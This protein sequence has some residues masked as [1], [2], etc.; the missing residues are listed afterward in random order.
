M[1]GRISGWNRRHPVLAILLVSLLAVV[2]N[3]YPV[4]FCG[5]SFVSPISVGRVVYDWWPSLPG[6]DPTQRYERLS[7]HGSDTGAAMWWEV[8]MGFVES[9]SL[10]EHG[11]IPLWNRYSHAG[12]TLIGQNETML[13]DP[14][15]LIVILGRG[16]AE[17]WDVKFVVAK[18]LFC[19]GFGLLILRLF[20]SRPLSL[21]YAAMGAYCGAFFYI[22]NHPSFF[23]LCYGPWILLSALA[24]LDR[25]SGWSAVWGLVWL[26]A[27]F[28]CFN[29]GHVETAVVL[30]GGLNLTAISF[31]LARCGKAIAAAK[32][33]GRMGLGTILFLGLTAPMWMSFFAALS[34]AFSIH[35]EVR[36]AQIPL[37]ALPGMFDD[38]FFLLPLRS[39]L[40]AA[41]AP[42]T[43]LLVMAG[44]IFSVLRWRELKGDI[45]F[46]VNGGA[47][48]LW[49]GFVFG[50]VPAPLIAAIP[51]LNRVGHVYVDFSYLLV[52]QLTIQSALGFTCLARE[53]DFRR[54]AVDLLWVGLIFGTMVL[55]FCLGI[56]H[57]PIPWN[58]FLCVAA[59]GIGAP[60]L[61]TYLKNRHR[62]IPVMGLAGIIILGFIPHFRFG[63]YTFG[64][65]NLLLIPGQREVLDAPSPAI[66]KIKSGRSDPFRVVGL[67][68]NLAGDYSA[69]YGLEDIRSCA[70]L[71]NGEYIKLMQK[72]PGVVFG[73]QSGW[74]ICVENPVAA[75]PLLNLLDVKYLLAQPQPQTEIRAGVDFRVADR[76]DFLVLENVDVWPRAFFSNK[77]LTNSSTEEFLKQLW[78]NSKQ[79]F[80]SLSPDEL[81]SQPGL[82]ALTNTKEAAILPATN[83]SMLPNS[84]AFDVHATSA[85]VVCL[86][87]GQAKD[88]TA[89]ANGKP[90]AV[91]TVNRAFKGVYLDQPG[92][93]HIE[94]IYR[95]RHWRLACL[96]FWISAASVMVLATIAAFC[97][98]LERQQRNPEPNPAI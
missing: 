51:L 36:V 29:A 25:Q 3:C 27:N 69:T 13:G 6:M 70:P 94:F 76:S 71:S 68:W 15:Q 22:N 61:F 32:V 92:D 72:S 79:P 43:S 12:D 73:G 64:N 67:R 55:L 16:C 38:L 87:E 7:Q 89:T 86:I 98:R 37:V 45:F 5:K 18:F 24:W 77:V 63:L 74:G 60:L 23:V 11:T 41:V 96:L 30:I 97:S 78:D 44:C 48:L 26:L 17:A 2:I 85:G 95:P 83:Y 62:R 84:T 19:V 59:G 21:I 34:G 39:D 20:G 28:A 90:K 80:V 57:Q 14:L 91:L 53:K 82:P 93:Y 47:I 42:G 10:L 49:G 66:E 8:P 81:Q 1:A 88:F 9:R 4:I 52:I 31:T 56:S 50:W 40:Y 58:Y 75:Q 46:W 33:I 65:D 54:A 35:S